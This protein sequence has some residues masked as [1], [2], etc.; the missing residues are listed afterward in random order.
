MSPS[1]SIGDTKRPSRYHSIVYGSSVLKGWL[2]EGFSV[3]REFSSALLLVFF[4][5]A[6]CCAGDV[7]LRNDGWS[8]GGTAAFQG[9]FLSGEIAAVRLAPAGP[10]PCTVE[11]VR[12]LFGGAAGT[13][14]VK[15]HVWEDGAGSDV[16]GTE[17]L[18]GIYQLTASNDAMQEID[19]GVAG[20]SVSGPFRVGVEFTHDGTPSVARD[21]DGLTVGRNFIMA[22]GSGWLKAETLGIAGD[23]IIRA[24]VGCAE[25]ARFLRGDANADGRLPELSDAVAFLEYMFLGGT[26]VTCEQAADVNDSGDLNVTDAVY[27]LQNLFLGGK[28]IEPP[29]DTCGIDP[30]GHD[31][32]CLSFV[33]CQ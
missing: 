24:M 9:G 7:E 32:P 21:G 10:F 17:L 33:P 25:G 1:E 18:A 23:W 14:T 11:R 19:L 3:M 2:L 31:L 15:V 30:T 22:E 20:V 13:R 29:V 16:P 5:V 8:P 26:K 27:L 6:V 4:G 12:F 28:A